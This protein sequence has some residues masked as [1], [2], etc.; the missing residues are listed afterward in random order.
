M[1]KGEGKGGGWS[2]QLYN[3]EKKH[4]KVY[5]IGL[6]AFQTIEPN[7]KAFFKNHTYETE[8]FTQIYSF[9]WIS[10]S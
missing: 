7:N 8:T 4:W 6:R 10:A 5:G 9:T 2:K 3:C 1:N